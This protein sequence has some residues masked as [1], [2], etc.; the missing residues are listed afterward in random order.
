[1]SSLLI[2][3]NDELWNLFDDFDINEKNK[4]STN[5]T[6]KCINIKLQ[7]NVYICE[8]CN[9]IREKFIDQQSEWRYNGLA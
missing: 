8:D 3:D 7:D 1:M 5:N 4:E 9:T 6:C 2:D